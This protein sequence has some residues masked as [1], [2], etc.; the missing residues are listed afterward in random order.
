MT[1]SNGVGALVGGGVV[2]LFVGGG[3]VGLFVGGGVVGLFVGN[4]VPDPAA[5]TAR[6]ESINPYGVP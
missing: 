4:G 6:Y 1:P 3:V 5:L 2:G